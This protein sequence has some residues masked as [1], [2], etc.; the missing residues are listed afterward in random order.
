MKKNIYTSRPTHVTQE[1]FAI[2]EIKRVLTLNKP[3]YVELTVLELSKWLTYDFHYNFI[4]KNFDAKLLFTDIDSLTYETKSEESFKHQHLF[5]VSNYPKDS[6]FFDPAD[7]EV[8]GK[9]KN[10]PGG[11][12]IHEFVR[13]K[14]YSMKNIDGKESNTTKEV[15]I[16]TG[17]NEFRDTLLN[18]KVVRHKKKRIQRKKKHMKSSKYHSHVLMTKDLFKMMVFI[19]LFIFIKT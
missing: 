4:K 12:I 15:N 11:K 8:F 3:I 18:R 2:H 6:K 14:I 9:M 7:K 5:D 13:L 17:F 19:H 1:I 10:M 16:A